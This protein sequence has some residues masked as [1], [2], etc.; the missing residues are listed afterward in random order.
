[1]KQAINHLKGE[2]VV[3]SI[4]AQTASSAQATTAAPAKAATK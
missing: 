1:L 3:V 4:R 2:P